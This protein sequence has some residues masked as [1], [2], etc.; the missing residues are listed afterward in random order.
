M[1]ITSVPDRG[2][3]PKRRIKYSDM[4]VERSKQGGYNISHMSDGYR[5]SNTYL[6]YTKRQAMKMHKDKY[7][8]KA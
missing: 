2:D 4:N 6:G 5:Q 1:A 8:G 3:D 7:E